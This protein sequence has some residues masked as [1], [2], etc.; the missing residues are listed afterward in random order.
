MDRKP[1]MSH[2]TSQ[3]GGQTQGAAPNMV[4]G[5]LQAIRDRIAAALAEAQSGAVAAVPAPQV[6]LVAVSKGHDAAAIEEAIGCGQRLF[7]ESRVQEAT[8]K[9]MPL[10]AMYPDIQLHLIGPLQT[11]KVA[12]AVRLFDVIESVDRDR[13]AAAL[14]K[15][16]QRAGRTL[17][18]FVQVN[19]G[20]EPQKAGIAPHEA[21]AFIARVRDEH[22]LDVKGLMCIPPVDRSPA[23]YF[24]LLNQIARRNNIAMLSMGMSD[25]FETA[26]MFGATHVRVGT[27]IFGSRA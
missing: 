18:C 11:N 12:D 19:I 17:P 3:T 14:A 21:D 24:A 4:A 16:M 1:A 10:K 26:I 20:E 25:D 6:E 23:P 15:E 22:G 13:I 7:G 8:A 9:W 5:R 27:A 2:T